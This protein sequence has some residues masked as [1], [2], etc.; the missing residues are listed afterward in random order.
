M[1]NIAEKY[2]ICNMGSIDSWLFATSQQ[3]GQYTVDLQQWMWHA[4]L[5]SQN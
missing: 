2:C 1:V 4:N 5:T 3:P